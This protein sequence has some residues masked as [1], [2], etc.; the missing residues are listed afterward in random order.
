MPRARPR[1]SRP[2]TAA[3]P[4]HQLPQARGDTSAPTPPAP[5]RWPPSPAATA[6]ASA[7]TPS[8]SRTQ[9]PPRLSPAPPPVATRG[10]TT[11]AKCRRTP[12]DLYIRVDVRRGLTPGGAERGQRAHQPTPFPRRQLVHDS[13]DVAAPMRGDLLHELPP[14]CGQLGHQLAAGDGGWS[15]GDQPRAHEPGD[16]PTG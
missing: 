8:R 5:P 15:A 16:H 4:D 10:S 11:G 7:V 3:A 1:R 12:A 9:A 13:G 2:T 14:V 6:A